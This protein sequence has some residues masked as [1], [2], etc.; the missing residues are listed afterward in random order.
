MKRRNVTHRKV[1]W[2]PTFHCRP[3]RM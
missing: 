2:S 3:T 1:V